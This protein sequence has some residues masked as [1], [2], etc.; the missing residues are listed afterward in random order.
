MSKESIL[1][2][3]IGSPALKNTLLDKKSEIN[4]LRK[5][6]DIR[7]IKE[8]IKMIKAEHSSLLATFE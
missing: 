1:E 7:L 2:A 6:L 5:E 3:V 8:A 4:V